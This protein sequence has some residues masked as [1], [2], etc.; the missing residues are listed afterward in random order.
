MPAAPAPSLAGCIRTREIRGSYFADETQIELVTEPSPHEYP[1]NDE[2][3]LDE[4]LWSSGGPRVSL[5]WTYDAN[6]CVSTSETHQVGAFVGDT[7]VAS[8]LLYTYECDEGA[9]PAEQSETWTATD[10]DGTVT[11]GE[12]HSTWDNTYDD[13]G[14]LVREEYAYD[15]GGSV[16]TFEWDESGRLYRS[17]TTSDDGDETTRTFEY[18]EDGRLVSVTDREGSSEEVAEYSYDDRGRLVEIDDVEGGIV[19]VGHT[20]TYDGDSPW[21]ATETVG[22]PAAD[23]YTIAESYQCAPTGR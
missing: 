23:G 21:P 22:D 1:W 7:I 17:K 10:Q 12:N 14:R 15:N 13:A 3:L 19:T 6:R 8:D 5:R 2:A 9:H 11:T 20:Y 16:T 18:D 4:E